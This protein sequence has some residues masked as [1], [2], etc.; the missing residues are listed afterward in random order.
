MDKAYENTDLDVLINLLISG[1]TFNADAPQGYMLVDESY[2]VLF[3]NSFCQK[4]FQLNDLPS[5]DDSVSYIS[6]IKLEFD[7]AN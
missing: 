1:N 6:K 4:Y 3:A 5:V 7:E 2:Q